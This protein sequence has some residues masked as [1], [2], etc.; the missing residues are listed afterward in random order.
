MECVPLVRRV[1]HAQGCRAIGEQVD[2]DGLSI[3]LVDETPDR[4]H[5]VPRLEERRQVPDA[6]PG[7][8]AAD[9]RGSSR[10]WRQMSF[11][12]VPARRQHGG[13]IRRR[14]A[15]YQGRDGR[16]RQETVLRGQRCAE[17]ADHRNVLRDGTQS[18]WDFSTDR[19]C[20]PNWFST[21][22]LRPARPPRRPL[23]ELSSSSP[24]QSS[25]SLLWPRFSLIS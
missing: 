16:A 6:Q 17:A 5:P 9:A 23:S 25:S 24:S 4:L 15:R 2:V 10:R 1:A 19:R 21:S 18:S 8:A 20:W 13:V 14:T 7:T 11:E 22:T 12:P 3:V